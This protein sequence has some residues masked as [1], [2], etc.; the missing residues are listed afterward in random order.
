MRRLGE[1]ERLG[2][3]PGRLGESAEPSQAL[4]QPAAIVDRYREG[5]SE[6][7]VDRVRGQRGEVIGG[8]FDHPLVVAPEEVRLLE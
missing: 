4:N 1:S 3:V 5:G 6:G 8:Q 7:L 2:L